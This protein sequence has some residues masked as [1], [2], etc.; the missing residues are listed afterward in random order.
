MRLDHSNDAR[1]SNG[2]IRL[3]SYKRGGQTPTGAQAWVARC[4]CERGL[5]VGVPLSVKQVV[6][7]K[8]RALTSEVES[9]RQRSRLAGE[10]GGAR[11]GSGGGG[12]GLDS[13]PSRRELALQ[14]GSLEYCAHRLERYCVWLEGRVVSRCVGACGKG[15]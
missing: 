3:A 6:A 10:G 11:P 4:T 13:T 14:P 7:R 2:G 15:C 5:V 9:A 8:L 12:G 1:C